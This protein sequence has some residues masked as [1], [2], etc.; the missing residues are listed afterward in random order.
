MTEIDVLIKNRD[1]IE[2]FIIEVQ[3]L[4]LEDYKELKKYRIE[5]TKLRYP[6]A[7]I[8]I[9]NTFKLIDYVLFGDILTETTHNIN[10]NN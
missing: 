4:T 5:Q 6:S 7:E 10:R 9:M 1:K 2:R 3:Q 8:F